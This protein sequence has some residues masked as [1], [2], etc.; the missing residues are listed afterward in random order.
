M[1]KLVQSMREIL[2]TAFSL[3]FK[4][5]A[6]HWNVEG[7]DFPQLHTLFNSQYDEIWESVDDIAEHL[8]ALDA[9]TPM[10]MERFL[11]LSHVDS[12]GPAP[13]PAR[14]MVL[15]LMKDHETMIA[16]LNAGIEAATEV[17]EQGIINFLAGRIEEHAKHRWMLRATSKRQ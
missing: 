6:F 4:T 16:L 15:E 3:Y 17:N 8:R 14:D 13:V 7:S 12:S 2:G 11:E 10:S 1:E 9:Y 5:H